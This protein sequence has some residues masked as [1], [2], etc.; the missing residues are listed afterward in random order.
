[1]QR[2]YTIEITADVDPNQNPDRL[3][4]EIGK[5]VNRIFGFGVRNVQVERMAEHTPQT[6]PPT[7]EDFL[8]DLFGTAIRRVAR[9]YDAR[10]SKT[11]KTVFSIRD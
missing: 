2:T 3:Q 7:L 1:M 11:N 5:G 9:E 8:G 4:R 6:E 10:K